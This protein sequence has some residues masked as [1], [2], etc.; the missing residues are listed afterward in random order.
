MTEVGFIS[1][2]ERAMMVDSTV[3]E[4]VDDRTNVGSRNAGG[5]IGSVCQS[6]NEVKG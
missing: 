1:S 5:R 6:G 4:V 3:P 2:A